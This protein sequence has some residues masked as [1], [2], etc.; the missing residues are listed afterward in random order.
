MIETVGW[1]GSFLLGICGVPLAWDAWRNGVAPGYVFLYICL[2]GELCIIVY[3]PWK[4]VPLHL[5]YVFNC[6]CLVI[7]IYCK[8]TRN[9]N[10]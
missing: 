8:A 1:L 9:V 10:T 3:T 5:N 7:T 6:I 2:V 4:H